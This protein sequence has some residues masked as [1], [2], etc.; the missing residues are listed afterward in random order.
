MHA[1]AMNQFRKIILTAARFGYP[2]QILFTSKQNQLNFKSFWGTE[3]LITV[4]SIA[5]WPCL[6]HNKQTTAIQSGQTKLVS[7]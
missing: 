5:F 3:C 4:K 1:V 6:G 7:K 2:I